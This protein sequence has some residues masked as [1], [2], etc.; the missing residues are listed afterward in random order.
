MRSIS[1]ASHRGHTIGPARLS[2]LHVLRETWDGRDFAQARQLVGVRRGLLNP[3]R[4]T[5]VSQRAFRALRDA[6]LRGFRAEVA[7]SPLSRST[8]GDFAT[9]RR[10][11]V[12]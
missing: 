11:S 12:L 3:A 4:L 5:L 10:R 9:R 8:R 1:S 6:G 2:E 7:A